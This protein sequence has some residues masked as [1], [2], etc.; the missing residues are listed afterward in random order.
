MVLVR[1]RELGGA[2]A[3]AQWR[4]TTV[5]LPGY[6]RHCH[7]G[8]VDNRCEPSGPPVGHILAAGDAGGGSLE[9]GCTVGSQA[10]HT[11]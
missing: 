6:R 7:S 4:Y 9:L 10:T 8:F 5:H 2:N 3:V 11:A 1:R